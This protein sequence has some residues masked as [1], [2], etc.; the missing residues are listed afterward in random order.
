VGLTRYQ[1][2]MPALGPRKTRIV[3]IQHMCKP[4]D[5]MM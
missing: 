2:R 5:R 3:K 1:T 4:P